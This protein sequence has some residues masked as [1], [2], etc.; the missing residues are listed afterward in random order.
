MCSVVAL[1]VAIAFAGGRERQPA[2]H[3]FEDHN[4]AVRM[5]K[6]YMTCQDHNNISNMYIYTSYIYIN[7]QTTSQAISSLTYYKL[8]VA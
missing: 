5:L 6:G 2:G 3:S 1:I 8:Y 4:E 7:L